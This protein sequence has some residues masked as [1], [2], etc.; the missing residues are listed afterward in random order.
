MQRP[1]VKT[2]HRPQRVGE[3]RVRIG[4]RVYGIAAEIKDPH[5]RVWA[6]LNALDGT[7]TVD[8]VV[9]HLVHRFPDLT[10]D[11]VR[12]GLDQLIEAGYVTDAV[13]PDPEVLTERETER[14]SRSRAFFEWVDLVPRE[15]GWHAQH[16]LRETKAILVGVGGTGGAAALALAGSGI[17]WLHCVEPDVVELSNLN[18]QILYTERDIGRP[19]VEAAV[20]RLQALNSDIAVTGGDARV[21]GPDMLAD[22]IRRFDLLILCADQPAEIRSWANIACMRTGTPW[23]YGGYHGPQVTAGIYRPG[24]GPCYE[25]IRVGAAERR[26]QGPPLTEYSVADDEPRIHPANA[27]SAGVSGNLVAHLAISS[28]TGAPGVPPNRVF[29]FNLARPD[30][31]FVLDAGEPHERCPACGVTP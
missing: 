16:R 1:R 23:V 20:E 10:E 2:A 18:R 14:Y 11:E 12:S 17:G 3:D 21:T 9:S 13:A 4:G 27:V 25:C 19:K 31:S 8:Q 15:N 7:R 29:G 28:I 24:T 22:L 5:G 30:H 26:E 6:M